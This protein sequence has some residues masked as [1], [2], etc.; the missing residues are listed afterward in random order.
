MCWVNAGTG[1]FSRFTETTFA[2]KSAFL[3]TNLLQYVECADY[4][5]KLFTNERSGLRSGLV[6][7]S[8]LWA[9]FMMPYRSLYCTS[10]AFVSDLAQQLWGELRCD[11]NAD[12]DVLAVCSTTIRG[13]GFHS[14]RSMCPAGK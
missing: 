9:N 7:T 2:Q 6:F 12:V 11:G 5:S 13:T 4:F 8:S 10:K 1:E 14:A 3:Q